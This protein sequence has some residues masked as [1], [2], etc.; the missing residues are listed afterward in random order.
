MVM[1]YL[2]ADIGSHGKTGK[3]RGPR[4]RLKSSYWKALSPR[5]PLVLLFAQRHHGEPACTD[6]RRVSKKFAGLD[7]RQRDGMR[8][9]MAGLDPDLGHFGVS[10]VNRFHGC[11]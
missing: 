5:Q 9:Q 2:P 7:L 4:I 11:R 1:G 6:Q 3:M 8:D 10:C